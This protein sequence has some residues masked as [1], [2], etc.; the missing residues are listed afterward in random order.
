MAS[1][2]KFKAKE[3]LGDGRG[4]KVSPFRGEANWTSIT[5]FLLMANRNMVTIKRI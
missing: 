2:D 5:N 3:V 4:W 1:P